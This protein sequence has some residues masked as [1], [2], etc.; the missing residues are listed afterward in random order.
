MDLLPDGVV[1]MTRSLKLIQMNLKAKELCQK[2]AG[3]KDSDPGLPSV[4]AETC[5]RLT[6][7]PLSETRPLIVECQASPG[8]TVRIRASWFSFKPNRNLATFP[9]HRQIILLL[10]KDCNEILHEELRLE[11]QKYDLTDR[12]AEIW[13]LLRQEHTYQEIA[14]ILQISLNTVKTHVKNVYA[15]KR[16]F[17][18]FEKVVVL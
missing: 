10:L 9:N 1:V 12:E 11:Q 15:K 14:Q 2:M 17:Q 5:Q 18:G 3:S 8:L 6:R 13:A 16:S 4:L 7:Q